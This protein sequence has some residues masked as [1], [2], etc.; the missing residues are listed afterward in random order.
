MHSHLIVMTFEG[1]EEAPRVYEAFQ[2]MRG[3]PLLGLEHAAAVTKDSHSRI[4]VFQKRYLSRTGVDPG[5]DLVSSAIALLFGDPPDEVVQV[6]IEKGFDDRFRQQIAQ[7]TGDNSSALLILMARDSN[8]DRSRLFGI[9]TLFKGIVFETT[10]PL[11][12]E[13]ILAKGWEA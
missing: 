10:L 4:A 3:S 5:D 9:L 1:E 11:E 8:V 12:V 6:L 13:A 7:A 2:R